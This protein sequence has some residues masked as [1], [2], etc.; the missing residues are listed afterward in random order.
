MAFV[1]PDCSADTSCRDGIWEA[2]C[3]NFCPQAAEMR[4]SSTS[5]QTDCRDSGNFLLLLARLEVNWHLPLRGCIPSGPV[6]EL[7]KQFC[8][9]YSNSFPISLRTAAARRS[10]IVLSIQV[11]SSYLKQWYLHQKC[12]FGSSLFSFA[13]ALRM[14]AYNSRNI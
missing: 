11:Q 3:P 10:W 6:P 7:C 14:M 5:S 1:V 9:C 4:A 13:T 2:F 8:T 12:Y